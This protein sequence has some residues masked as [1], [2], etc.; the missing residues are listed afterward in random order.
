MRGV[1]VTGTDTGVGKTVVAALL[2]LGSGAAYWKPVQCGTAPSTDRADVARWTGLPEDRL[3]PEAYRLALPASPHVAAHAAGVVIDP[4]R[5]TLPVR[6]EP[7]V[8]EGAGGILV[9]LN[10]RHTMLD[11][12]EWLGLPVILVARTQLGTINHTLLS[13]QTLRHR[14]LTIQGLVLNGEPVPTTTATLRSWGKVPL[15]AELPPLAQ[16]TPAAL[17]HAYERYWK[18]PLTMS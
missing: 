12:M 13:L 3:L 7:L 5:L 10:D 1:F 4:A 2:A 11:L 17:T 8:V 16:L 9:P 6:P 18:H 14:G 15:L